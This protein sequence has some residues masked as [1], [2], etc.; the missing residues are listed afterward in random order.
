MQYKKHYFFILLFVVSINSTFAIEAT[1][2]IDNMILKTINKDP[3]LKANLQKIK[4]KEAQ[5]NSAKSEFFPVVDVSGNAKKYKNLDDNANSEIDRNIGLSVSQELFSGFSSV[6]KVK[7]M[8][9]DKDT[10]YFTYLAETDKIS[11]EV[12][13]AYLNYLKKKEIV[14]LSLT[15]L[16][17]HI[18]IYDQIKQK[19]DHGLTRIS[20]LVK[21]ESRKERAESTL[22]VAKDELHKVTTEYFKL[23][24][25]MPSA[26]IIPNVNKLNLPKSVDVA[27]QVALEN[28]PK[29]KA[30]TM[31]IDSS[32][33]AYKQQLGS[34]SPKLTLDASK[35]WDNNTYSAKGKHE[36]GLTLTMNLFNGGKNYADMKHEAYAIEEKKYTKVSILDDIKQQLTMSL[37]SLSILNERIVHLD[38]QSQASRLV[39]VAYK[40][41]LNIGKQTIINVLDSEN[42]LYQANISLTNA[43]YEK[44]LESYKILYLTG[45]LLPQLNIQL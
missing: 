1:E 30:S 19:T 13:N 2:S 27:L 37:H 4:R 34:V 35:Q 22:L 8:Q 11:L 25:V 10:A 44:M 26:L 24:G 36:V 40:E 3:T 12:V 28:N 39:V 23:T 29:V 15:N 33:Y 43:L 41:E 7:Q 31:D 16:K 38:K 9:K 6:S 20:D 5:I 18:T 17:T 21:V 32:E 45:D 42:E 14:D